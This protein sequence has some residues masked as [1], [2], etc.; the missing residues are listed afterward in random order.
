[1][2]RRIP[3][4]LALANASVRTFSVA[5]KDERF[6]FLKPAVPAETWPLTL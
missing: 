5:K 4:S 3:S 2:T 6:D 1:M